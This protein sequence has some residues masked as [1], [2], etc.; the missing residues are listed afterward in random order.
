MSLTFFDMAK[1]VLRGAGTGTKTKRLMTYQEIWR[2]GESQGLINQLE[3]LGKTPMNTLGAM[4]Y[5]DCKAERPQFGSVGSP[6]LFYIL[7]DFP[8]PDKAM[9]A[10][11]KAVEAADAMA[12]PTT[13]ASYKEE[14]L[15][16][17]LGYYVRGNPSFSKGKSVYTKTII[18]QNLG[19]KRKKKK[20]YAQWV[21]P[22]MV[23]V[24]MPFGEWQA[25][26][27]QFGAHV[28]SGEMLLLY[29]FE[30]KQS[31]NSG[32][33]REAF[34]Q[35]ISNSSWANE[36][37]LVAPEIADDDALIEELGRLSTS[38][39][40][41]V[42]ELDM[43]DIDNSI[44]RFPARRKSV[45]DWE[46]M[47]KLAWRNQDFREFLDCVKNDFVSGKIHVEEYENTIP[48]RAAYLDKMGQGKG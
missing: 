35:A 26:L 9:K 48:D 44:V 19:K 40:I 10:A 29:S 4:M 23:G 31:L 16:P 45:L 41:G 3:T 13:K 1:K 18:H 32:N 20:D 6:A 30:I 34:F 11:D 5:R 46:T 39:G 22:D 36:G 21:H 7:E 38:F 15:H 43:E 25:S 37:Y 47:N 27:A 12:P 2:V 8:T 42:I 17:F 24:Y 14:D 33:Y 28:A